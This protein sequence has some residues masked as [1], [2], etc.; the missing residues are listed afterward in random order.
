MAQR[1]K[2]LNM[3]WSSVQH[4]TKDGCEVCTDDHAGHDAEFDILV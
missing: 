1:W 2:N 4:S 3:L